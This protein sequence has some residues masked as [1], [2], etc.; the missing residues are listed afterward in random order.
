MSTDAT[1]TASGATIPE[2]VDNLVDAVA[3]EPKLIA[4][5][6]KPLVDL[7]PTEIVIL[8]LARDVLGQVAT[9]YTNAEIPTIDRFSSDWRRIHQAR[10]HGRVAA[11]AEAADDAIFAFLNNARHLA[12]ASV[13]DQQ[14][15]NKRG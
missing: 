8:N 13:T 9:R 2:A 5:Q 14:L 4:G 12:D 7:T 11:I 10:T 15:H 1:V 3:S 6:P